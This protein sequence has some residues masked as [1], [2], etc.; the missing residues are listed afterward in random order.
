MNKHV[1]PSH[2]LFVVG[3]WAFLPYPAFLLFGVLP[4]GVTIHFLSASLAFAFYHVALPVM[5]FYC[6]VATRVVVGVL[7]TSAS[8]SAEVFG[9]GV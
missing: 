5:I 1:F 7:G 2:W 3:W 9:V 8:G 4:R 6:S